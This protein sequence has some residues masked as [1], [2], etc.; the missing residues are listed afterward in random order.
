M[1][2]N[3]PLL[4]ILAA[5]LAEGTLVHVWCTL[6]IEAIAL[7]EV[8]ALFQLCPI[9]PVPLAV[10]GVGGATPVVEVLG[11]AAAVG[12]LDPW[13]QVS[14][15]VVNRPELSPWIPPLLQPGSLVAHTT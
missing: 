15:L 9:V 6:P 3:S 1:S 11:P 10:I 7:D 14:S 8:G 12:V 13:K 4:V 5:W 2:T